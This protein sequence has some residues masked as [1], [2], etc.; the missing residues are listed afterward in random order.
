MTREETF[1]KTYAA[2]AVAA[3][4]KVGMSA[5]VVLS[6][7]AH[8][9]AWGTSFSVRTRR[10]HFGMIAAGSPNAYWQGAKTQSSV[11]KL[12]FRVYASHEA[13][14]E[15][16]AS[17]ISRKY[18][19]AFAASADPIKYAAAIAASPYI[20]EQ[21]GDDRAAYKAALIRNASTIGT[22]AKRLHIPPS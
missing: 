20:S 4:H 12:W 7:A 16:F 6:Q 10:N 2:A 22:I 13:S 8:E 15:D 1:V 14:F 19:T 18:P 17:L 11:S 21:N 5:L 9:G 3:A